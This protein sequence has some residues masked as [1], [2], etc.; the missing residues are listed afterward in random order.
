MTN[1][2]DITLWIKSNLP[3]IFFVIIGGYYVI[4]PHSF[5]THDF[6]N[7]YFSALFIKQGIFTSEIYFPFHFNQTVA[8][9]GYVNQ[10]LSFAPNTPFLALFFVPF[11][12]LPLATAKLVFNLISL[13]LL[14]V[15]VKRLAS[16]LNIHWG[17]VLIFPLVFLVPIKNNLLFGQVYFLLFFLLSEGFLAYQ[18]NQFIRTALWWGLAISL[19]VFPIVLIGFLLFKHHFK[20]VGYLLLSVAILTLIS[21]SVTGLAPWAFF[22]LEALP[23]FNNGE[24]AG[25]YVANY[26]SL[27]MF[28][29]HILVFDAIENPT[30][31]GQ[32]FNSVLGLMFAVKLFLVSVAIFITKK[33]KGSFFSFSFW[34]F[35]SLISSPYGSTYSLLVLAFLYFSTGKLEI[36]TWGKSLI[37]LTL[38]FLTLASFKGDYA[39]PF[40]YLRLYLMV[41]LFIGLMVLFRSQIPLKA[42]TLTALI[43]GGIYFLFLPETTDTSK[44]YTDFSMPILTYDYSIHTDKLVYYYWNSSA[45]NRA[46]YTIKKQATDTQNVEIIDNQIYY[47]NQQLTFDHS[48]KKMATR[49]NENQI[50]FLSDKNRGVGFYEL[51][52]IELTSGQ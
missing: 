19:K 15:S 34:L 4:P 36:Q 10:F 49:V 50:V 28:L 18:K 46:E 11:T 26:Q 24:I 32:Y 16:H 22:F 48:N 43:S 20:A 37:I 41:G 9:L 12:F 3:L 5:P 21:I 30:G 42:I 8:D 40:N 29:K 47:Q 31:L 14:M 6:G 27:F 52:K 45:R 13:L 35:I 1:L 51:R 44:R 17:Y 7:Y 39:F 25:A 33:V 23:R 38:T 2:K